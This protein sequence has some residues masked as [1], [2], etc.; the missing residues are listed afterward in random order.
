MDAWQ[1][2]AHANFMSESVSVSVS[3]SETCVHVPV[4]AWSFFFFFHMAL[5][6]LLPTWQLSLRFPRS[7][8]GGAE[9]W[10][11]SHMRVAVKI[12]WNS[13]RLSF[14]ERSIDWYHF[15]PNKFRW[16]VHLSEV[17]KNVLSARISDLLLTILLKLARVSFARKISPSFWEPFQHTNAEIDLIFFSFYSRRNDGRPAITWTRGSRTRESSPSRSLQRSG[18]SIAHLRSE[19]G[20]KGRRCDTLSKVAERYRYLY[21]S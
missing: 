6:I 10:R 20:F 7:L 12:G 11:D 19:L 13:R 17:F 18:I 14:K 5:W 3:D 15:K 1:K 9:I 21:L 2:F 8:R 16:T 4:C